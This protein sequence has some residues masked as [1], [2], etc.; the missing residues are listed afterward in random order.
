MVM[1]DRLNCVTDGGWSDL[2]LLFN[3]VGDP[4]RHI[5][6]LQLAFKPMMGARKEM[7]GHVA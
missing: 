7:N 5:H 4:T 6:E 3:V 1:Q 2:V